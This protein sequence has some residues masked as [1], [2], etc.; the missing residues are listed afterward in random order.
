VYIPLGGNRKGLLKQYRNIA[1]VWFLTGFWHGASWNYIIWGSYFGIILMLEKGFLLNLFSKL[2]ARLG[3]IKNIYSIILIIFGWWIFTFE[4]LAKGTSH[5]LYM[6]GI[7]CK[8]FI[9]SGAIYDL[10]HYLP[11]FIIAAIGSTPL[12]KKIFYKFFES[13]KICRTATPFISALLVLIC[14]AFL[15]DSSFNPFLYFRF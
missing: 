14:V 1:I 15:V 12:P 7:S 10:I 6:F 4:D 11:F 5:L 2:P 3:F 9:D 8:G 13:S